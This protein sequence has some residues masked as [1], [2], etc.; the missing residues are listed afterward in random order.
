VT[1]FFSGPGGITLL[2]G[3]LD[4]AGDGYLAVTPPGGASRFVKIERGMSGAWSDGARGYRVSLSVSIFRPRLANFIQIRDTATGQIVWE[5]RILDLFR[6]T[7]R[8][9]GR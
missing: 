4:L 7:Y 3:T 6:V 8:A 9:G 1:D 5:K 2:S